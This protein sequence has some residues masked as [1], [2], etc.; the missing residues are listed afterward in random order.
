MGSFGLGLGAMGLGE[1]FGGHTKAPNLNTQ[2][3]QNYQN[4]TQNPPALPQGMQDEINKSLDINDEQQNRNLRDVYKNLRPGTDYTTDSAYQRDNANLQRNLSSNRA[5]AMMGP[6]LQYL[7]PQ[8][9]GLADQAEMSMYEPMLKAGM[10]SQQ[11][12]GTKQTF[13]NIGT[14]LMQKA[15]WPQMFSGFGGG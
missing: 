15:L 11:Q 7:Q 14:L 13:G 1:L 4:F 5:N 6:T 9:Q 8:Q 3:V 10:Q 12:A 2:Q